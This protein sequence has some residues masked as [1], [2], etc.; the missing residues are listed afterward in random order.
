MYKRNSVFKKNVVLLLSSMWISNIG[1]W[2]Y[3]IALNLIILQITGSAIAVSVLYI[4][5][6]MAVFFTNSWVGSIIDRYNQKQLMVILDIVRA[7]TILLMTQL[8]S[9]IWIYIC[10]FV[11]QM[12][13][14]TFQSASL[15]CITTIVPTSKQQKFNAMKSFVQSSGFVIGPSI[16][17][18]LFL[19][20]SPYLA[21][22]VNSI[23]LLLSAF[24]MY[25]VKYD[26]QLKELSNINTRMIK[27]DWT[28]VYYFAKN[29]RPTIFVYCFVSSTAVIMAGLDSMEAAFSTQVLLLSEEKY[30]LLVTVAGIGFII[31]SIF[32]IKMSN[33]WKDSS[34]I[35][36]GSIFTALGYVIYATS[37][38]FA[39]A[40]IGFFVLTFSH[41]F[42]SVGILTLLQKNIPNNIFGR[43]TSI[44]SIF[45]AL[46]GVICIGLVGILTIFISLK[47][48]VVGMSILF[49]S[50]SFIYFILSKK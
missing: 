25:F 14:S 37:T 29:H 26:V 1:E 3:F 46:V 9:L 18:V 31:G 47:M 7:L 30:G 8:S 32:N 2:I 45:E 4:L 22:Y 39:F 10:S 27:E 5:P 50:L 16:A 34:L 44:F 20:G 17:G 36:Y 35:K 21:M 48:I 41:S 33:K 11:I 49:I 38:S 15:T 23:A 12:L 19:I 6:Y 40:A 28:I 13:N 42:V 43:V 24:I